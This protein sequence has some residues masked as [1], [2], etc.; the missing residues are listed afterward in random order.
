MATKKELDDMLND[1]AGNSDP[2]KKKKKKKKNTNNVL[3]PLTLLKRL[4]KT[5][6]RRYA[7]S[8]PK[9][10]LRSSETS[11]QVSLTAS[12]AKS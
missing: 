2:V 9:K 7:L 11:Q 4:R 10:K 1:L 5:L 12:S 6:P 8:T 3:M